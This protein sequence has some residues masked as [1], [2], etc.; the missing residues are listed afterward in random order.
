M[1]RRSLIRTLVALPVALALRPLLAAARTREDIA[2]MQARWT[3]FLPPGFTPPDPS[4][5]LVRTEAQWQQQ[6]SPAAYEILREGGT[7]RAFSSA[8]NDEKRDGVFLCS[9]C[10][11]PLFSSETKYD[12]RTGWP[13]FFTHIPGTLETKR[14]FKMVWPRTEYHC[15][16]CGGHQGHLFK[17]GPAPTEERWCNNRTALNFLATDFG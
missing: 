6:L 3:D 15:I 17:D 9:G 12:S 7:E 10:D 11:L 5:K 2:Q 1:N 8:L 4:Q 16:R 13:S 14:D